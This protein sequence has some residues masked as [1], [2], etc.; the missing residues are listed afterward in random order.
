[1]WQ[2]VLE[3]LIPLVFAIFTPVILLLVNRAL[4]AMAKRWHLES[5]LQ[6]EDKVD[7]LILKGIKAVEQKSLKALKKDADK[8][9][10]EAK[11]ADAMQFVNAQL[12]HM[13]LPEKASK[14]LEMLIE[15][16]LFDGAKEKPALPA[17][18]EG[19]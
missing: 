15:S 14:E 10:G 4:Q 9:A 2:T 3:N 7:E 18:V 6:Y 17:A 8:T 12:N 5:V 16:K 1:M 19:A 11:L 13:K